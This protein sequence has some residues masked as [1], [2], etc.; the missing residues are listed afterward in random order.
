MLLP[1]IP[2]NGFLELDAAATED[3][4]RA[5]N[6]Q[7]NLATA[8][9]LHQ[10]QVLQVA[11]AACVCD[12]NGADGGQELHELGVDTGLLAFDVRGVDQEFRAVR[13]EESDVFLSKS[14]GASD[15]ICK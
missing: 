14:A 1:V 6:G 3:V 2:S 4:Q 13:L 15:R 10:L 11:S 12:G 8:Q 5:A 9:L 7:V